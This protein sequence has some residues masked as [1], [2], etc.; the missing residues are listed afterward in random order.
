M[1]ERKLTTAE[2]KAKKS[3]DKYESRAKKAHSSYLKAKSKVSHYEKLAKHEHGS[4]YSNLSKKWSKKASA[5]NKRYKKESKSLKK[6]KSKYKDVTDVQA[7]HTMNKIAAEIQSHKYSDL[8]EGNAAIYQSDGSDSTIIY[9]A[10]T[11][12]ESEDTSS[13]ITSYPVDTGSP[14]SNYARISGKQVSISGI[15]TGKTRAEALQKFYTLRTWNS[16]HYELT[17]KGNVYYK[18]LM[19]SDLQQKFDKLEDNLQ[20][21]ITFQFV[22]AAN[23]TTTKKKTHKK[24][25]KSSKTT[26]GSRNKK[27]TALTVKSGD[28]LWGLSKRYGKSVSWLQKVNHIKNANLIYAGQKIRVK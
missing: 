26:A 20:V 7:A 21:S 9:I 23:I 2:E 4:K 25:S 16:R 15:I 3:V 1:A 24:S 28:T 22:Y 8:N 6:A 13:N 19:I 17:Y 12:T 5:D 18:H 11:E 27:Y 10:P 14:R